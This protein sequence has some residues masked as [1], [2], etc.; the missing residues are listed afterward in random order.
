MTVLEDRSAER[1]DHSHRD[2]A[3]G[4]LR[5]TVFGAMDGLVTNSSL[6]AGVG[7]SGV[8]QHGLVVTGL[9][10]LLAGA[11]SM[12]A[13]EWVSIRSANQLLAAEV[14]KERLELHRN[15]V[16]ERAE[17]AAVLRG[18]GLSDDLA[19]LAADEITADPDVALRFHSR[20]E[21]GA[22]LDAAPSPWLAGGSSMGAFAVGAAVPLL[23]LVAGLGLV[24][25][26]VLAGIAAFVAGALVT[27]VT[28]RPPLAA[29]LTQL[30][31]AV[32]ATA[33]T[34]GIGYLLGAAA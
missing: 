6:L 11:F 5:P 16:S 1:H 34:A 13:G 8:A 3:G 29:G 20:E 2:V 33:V 12:A 32:A 15:P 31:V 23:A 19:E 14:E 4:W 17:L 28:G 18:Y 26:L 25:A 22:T 30:A 7:A 21:L 9:A 10:G 24:V 27:R